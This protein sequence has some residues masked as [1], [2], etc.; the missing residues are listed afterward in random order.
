MPRPLTDISFV[1]PATKAAFERAGI[2]TAEEVE[3]LGA[4]AAYLRLLQSG[5]PPHFIG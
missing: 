4:D 2:F 1:G 5:T 3:A